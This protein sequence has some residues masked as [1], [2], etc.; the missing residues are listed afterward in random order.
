MNPWYQIDH[1][2]ILDSAKKVMTKIFL[3]HVHFIQFNARGISRVL[4]IC[5]T[6]AYQNHAQG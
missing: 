6:L 1:S 5:P 4:T 3:I 2:R